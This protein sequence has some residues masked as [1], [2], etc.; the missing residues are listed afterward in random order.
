MVSVVIPAHNAA[1]TI[2]ASLRALENQT[3]PRHLY[4]IIVVDDGSTDGT[5]EA[6]RQF[7]PSSGSANPSDETAPLAKL[8]RQPHQGAAAARNAGARVARGDVILFL[9]ADCIPAPDWLERMLS[10]VSMDGVAGAGGRIQTRQQCLIPRFIQIEYDE[11]Y[12]R[13]ARY[14][15]VDFVSSATAAYRRETF[16]AIG[17][18]DTAMLGAEDVDL[19]FRLAEAG[20][21]LVFAPD[22]VVYHPHPVTL[23]AYVRRKF[24]YARWRAAVYSRHPRKVAD[25]S[26][27]PQAQK[28]QIALAPIIVLGLLS[29]MV[30]RPLLIMAGLAAGAFLATAGSLMRRAWQVD[31]RIALASPAL[32]FASAMAA[33]AGLAVGTFQRRLV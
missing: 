12:E 4:E 27:T 17:G 2:A 7:M 32:L 14:R 26:R 10:H 21:K 22:A 28:L 18:F 29:G 3:I 8:I 31:P 1:G 11:R 20:Y 5:A 6:A 19:S 16:Q 33:A 23:W 9:D 15:S 25:D 24:Q 30:W 13:V